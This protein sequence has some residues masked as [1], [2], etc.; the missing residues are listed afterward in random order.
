[1]PRTRTQEEKRKRKTRGG[2]GGQMHCKILSIPVVVT[3]MVVTRITRQGGGE[4]GEILGFR[5]TARNRECPR[6]SPPCGSSNQRVC[7]QQ[8]KT[9]LGGGGSHRTWGRV[10]PPRV[11]GCLLFSSVLCVSLVS[12]Y[13]R[14]MP[15]RETRSPL[16]TRL[17]KG[18]GEVNPSNPSLLP[19]LPCL[20]VEHTLKTGEVSDTTC[21]HGARATT[22]GGVCGVRRH[23]GGLETAVLARVGGVGPS[24]GLDTVVN[25]AA[26]VDNG[27]RLRLDLVHVDRDRSAAGRWLARGLRRSSRTRRSRP[28][29]HEPAVLKDALERKTLVGVHDDQL[30]DH[31]LAVIRQV[32]RELVDL[33]P[34]DVGLDLRVGV[35]LRTEREFARRHHE[36]HHTNRPQVGLERVVVSIQHLRSSVRKGAD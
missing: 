31:V 32:R 7:K 8:K 3:E 1:M 16:R 20:L 25:R 29:L 33:R 27:L 23:K 6:I 19:Q 14:H 35:P 15:L 36:Y 22:L 30:E 24:R 2:A 26:C 4:T 21:S 5:A 11:L 18:G 9:R 28:L 12:S 34:A 17:R 10:S 13:P